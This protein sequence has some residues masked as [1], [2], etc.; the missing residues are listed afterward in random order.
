MNSTFPPILRKPP[1]DSDRPQIENLINDGYSDSVIAERFNVTKDTIWS[2][3]KR[4][5]LPSGSEMRD[6]QLVDSMRVLWKECY[7]VPE[8]AET[9][10]ISEQ[11]VY[12]K[13]SQHKIRETPRLGITTPVIPFATLKQGIT[14]ED[15]DETLIITHKR[16]PKWALVPID[17]YQDLVNGVFNE[18]REDA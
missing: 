12:M 1:F 9:L 16:K 10:N 13:L 17:Q 18:L 4:W 7:S 5:K 15:E 14:P 8:M 11:M 3:R 6:K 2:R